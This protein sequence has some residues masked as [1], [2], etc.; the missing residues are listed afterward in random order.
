MKPPQADEHAAVAATALTAGLIEGMLD[1]VCLVDGASLRV[2]A[3]NAA[4]ADLLGADVP[5]LRG[6]DV[7]GLCATP[8]DFQFWSDAAGG[9]E[10]AIESQ[11]WLRRNDGT[12]V[13]VLRRVS[14][15]SAAG[16]SSLFVLV[17]HDRSEQCRIE[18]E[19]ESRVAELAATL[20]STADGILV[21]DLAGRIRSFNHTFARLWSLPDEVLRRRD[22]HEVA[23]F[24][25]R[26]VSDPTGYAHRLAAI[27]D[28]ELLQS[29]DTVILRCGR[30]LQRVARPQS[31]RG[32][33]VGRVFSFRDISERLAA[34]RRIETLSHTDTLTGLPT[35]R[36]LADRVQFATAL[37]QREGTS[38]AL[39]V[40]GLDHFRH[41]ND[42]LGH[43]FGDRVLCDIAGRL[44]ACMRQVDTVAR[45]GGDEFVVL[46]HQA[47]AAGA[48][49]AARRILETMQGPFAHGGLSFTVTCS[50]GIALYPAGGAQ[51]DDLLRH[52]HGAM[53][54]VK[55]AGRAAYR[56]HE[57]GDASGQPPARG[58]LRL[59]HAMRQGLA[60][61][62][63]R[64][65]YQPQVDMGSRRVLGAEA[66]LRWRDPELGDVPP[67]EFIP[68]AEASG[69]IIAIGEWVLR[70]AVQQAARWHAQGRDLVVSINVS[71]VQFH[72]D[73]FV[74]SVA[75]ALK[76]AALPAQLLEL[77]LTES[78]LIQNA[79]DALLR[80]QALSG[81][82]VKLAI[83][84]FGT[85]YSSLGYLK[86]FPIDRLKI[87]RS[88]VRGL[89]SDASDAGIVNAIV[90][91]GRALQLEVVAE[92][93]ETEAQRAFLAGT[94]CEQY[95]GFL[96]APAL[97]S[98]SFEARL[99]SQTDVIGSAFGRLPSA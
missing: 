35:R 75:A 44:G 83:D 50:I 65:H 37:A 16:G 71:A 27:E 4:A 38:F 11:T 72:R 86:R 49:A 48:E 91:L 84:D 40:A 12:C 55:Q 43:E 14:R 26:S 17:M 62:H 77:E 29:V 1:A 46:A 66:L 68:V 18:G 30:V 19:L 57:P 95:Q 56:F 67:G 23:A 60:H 9:L 10:Q 39:L 36:V 97:D 6:R 70:Q 15:L 45:L 78:I 85:G 88:F 8:E 51:L 34:Q 69:F 81:L 87:D 58:R 20:E 47:D 80:L 52:A 7:K 73:G 5:G 61:G 41:I 92:G 32:A 98:A 2:V 22:A 31:S 28:S 82:G 96:F 79:H 76:D 54:Q 3:A 94:G 99:G 93:V 33:S 53:Q 74:D 13:P 89:P 42:T 59:D 63:F 25:Q 21:T 64:V 90:S 24:M